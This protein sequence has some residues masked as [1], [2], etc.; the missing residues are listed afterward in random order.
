MLNL[1]YNVIVVVSLEN[2]NIKSNIN[3]YCNN[4]KDNLLSNK[5]CYHDW[6]SCRGQICI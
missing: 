6:P 2:G 1:Q 5:I 4:F 3:V